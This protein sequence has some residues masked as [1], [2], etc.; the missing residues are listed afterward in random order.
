MQ[1]WMQGF[2]APAST[3]RNNEWL[4]VIDEGVPDPERDSGSVRM[5]EILRILSAQ[6]YAVGFMPH[7]GM[8]HDKDIALAHHLDIE[9]IGVHGQPDLVSWL[10]GRQPV[11][12]LL[13]R[14][15]VANA[16]MP[17]IR[18][19]QPNARVL[20]DTVDLHYVRL[21]REAELGVLSAPSSTQLQAIKGQELQA[22][23]DADITLVVSEVER[24]L[25][26]KAVPT[27]DVR[28]LSNIHV[29]TE[30]TSGFT[31][32]RD[33][34]FVGGMAHSPN[35]DA[36]QWFCHE[37]L[38]SIRSQVPD[39]TLHIVGAIS[40]A[41]RDE[42]SRFDGVRIHGQ[43]PDLTPLLETCRISVAPLRY[44]AGVKGKVNLAM[45]HGL[46]VVMTSIAAE[47]MSMTDRE[48]ALIAD[49]AADF[50][51]AVLRLHSDAVLW[52]KLADAG[53]NNIRKHFSREIAAET[54]VGALP[55]RP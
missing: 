40:A 3:N 24:E 38:P 20:F 46:P 4:L 8:A 25:L 39:M 27:A 44:G 28:V 48:D 30:A 21:T 9:L 37:V 7:D 54:L 45:S 19:M 31:S 47:G 33:L 49:N 50:A 29:V 41:Q 51:E 53:K 5:V 43:L 17:L 52:Q 13:C 26:T 6:G 16:H 35:L 1:R 10:A 42:L 55:R 12:A 2:R 23:R 22:I 14:F 18:A 15:H 32:R 36:M 34:L 11:A